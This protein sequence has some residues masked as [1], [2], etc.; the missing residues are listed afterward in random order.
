MGIETFQI[1]DFVRNRLTEE[2]GKIVRVYSDL[3]PDQ[4]EKRTLAY[5]VSLPNREAL[6]RETEVTSQPDRH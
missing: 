1:G 3:L 4:D 6:W 5:I 2:Q